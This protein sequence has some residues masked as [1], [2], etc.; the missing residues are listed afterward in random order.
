MALE[1]QFAK[2]YFDQVFTLFLESIK[3]EGRK[4][5]KAYDGVNNLFA[6]ATPISDGSKLSNDDL[7][8]RKLA[9]DRFR[10]DTHEISPGKGFTTRPPPIVKRIFF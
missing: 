6:R 7:D 1:S 2:Q 4:T 10:D 5:F 8:A 9:E 3:P